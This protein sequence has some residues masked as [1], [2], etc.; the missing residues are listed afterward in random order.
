MENEK[1]SDLLATEREESPED[2]QHYFLSFEDFW[3]RKLWHELTDIL[4]NFYKEPASANQRLRL[5]EGFVKTFA[6]KINQL[7]RQRAPHLPHR[8]YFPRGQASL[9]RRLRLL[10]LARR[11]VHLSLGKQAESRAELDKAEKVLD[12]FD[13][14]ETVVHASFYRVSADYYQQSHEFAAYYRTTLLYLACVE[15]ADLQ[16]PER[17]RI[18]YDLSIAAL[19]S[20]TI[21][22]FGELLL[23]PILDSLKSTEHAWLRDLLFAFNRGDLH[24]YNTLQQH[25][26]ANRLLEEHESFLYQKISLSAL[27]QL[28][29]S[30]A[31]QDRSMTFATISQETKVQLDEIEHLIMKALSLGLLRGSI[32]QVDEVARISWVQPKVLDRT[33]I[34]GMRGR[35]RE[36]GG[37]VERLGNWI[38]GVGEDVWAS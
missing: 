33:G 19:V 32:D 20:E 10:A 11:P 37:G 26:S 18:A 21:Y 28:V 8:P 4:V 29:F 30:R 17:R 6:D 12:T 36:W 7:K 2:L 1:I 25:K 27:T 23:H 13:S 14:V 3:E 15:L 5:Y 16:E 22:N 24:A 35:L 38:E 34:E 9:T 31:P